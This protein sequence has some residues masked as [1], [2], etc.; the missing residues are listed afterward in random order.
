MLFGNRLDR[1]A[2]DERRLLKVISRV[3]QEY[4]TIDAASFGRQVANLL[5]KRAA[6]GDGPEMVFETSSLKEY[7][8]GKLIMFGVSESDMHISYLPMKGRHIEHETEEYR[9][10]LSS[11][12]D[13]AGMHLNAIAKTISVGK[14]VSSEM[15]KEQTPFQLGMARYVSGAIVMAAVSSANSEKAL[16]DVV[17][18]ISDYDEGLPPDLQKDIRDKLKISEENDAEVKKMVEALKEKDSAI[19]KKLSQF[20]EDANVAT[21]W[22][23]TF[24]DAFEDSLIY[25]TH[26]L[27][28]HKWFPRT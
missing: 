6:I 23:W 12:P 18:A 3:P 16:N 2:K 13:L 20:G 28:M 5:V 1:L 9:D 4:K 24:M 22:I 26:G 17:H 21:K 7:P 8:F 15:E 19:A 10:L 27:H 14:V 11:N 25:L